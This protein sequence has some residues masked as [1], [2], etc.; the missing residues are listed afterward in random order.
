MSLVAED[1]LF[2][3]ELLKQAQEA[4]KLAF[5]PADGL[6]GG[7]PGGAPGGGGDPGNQ[8][9][10]MDPQQQAQAG[11][12]PP[13]AGGGGSDPGIQQMIQQAV[14]QA[15]MQGGGGMGGGAGGAQGLK[16]KIDQNAVMLQILKILARIADALKI[17]IP[18]SEMV[19]NQTDL[20]GLAQ[21]SQSGSPMPGMDPT[22]GTG[23]GAAGGPQQ[24]AI[25]PMPGMDASGVPGQQKQGS[26]RG[27]L[28]KEPGSAVDTAPLSNIS[29]R[30]AA[31]GRILKARGE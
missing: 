20:M 14:Q 26:D 23:G 9:T 13:P 28:A 1:H 5:I 7:A 27:P 25:P 6:A 16:P 11:A 17:P 24:G 15:M 2:N 10:G 19:V 21:A 29:N 4:T 30:A 18:A 31:I 3:V 22:A 8:P 12:A